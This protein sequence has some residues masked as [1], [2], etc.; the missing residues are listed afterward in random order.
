MGIERDSKID[1]WLTEDSLFL[2]SC[3]VRDGITKLDIAKKIGISPNTII[4][5]EKQYP[6]FAEAMT[7]RS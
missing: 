4:K 5:W 3:W 2:I 7:K 6:Q 1:L